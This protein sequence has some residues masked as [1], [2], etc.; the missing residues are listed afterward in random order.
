[1][2]HIRIAGSSLSLGVASLLL[3]GATMAF[4]TDQ[5]NSVGNVFSA[6]TI[7]SK[8]SDTDETDQ[9]TI[10][11]SF[12]FSNGSPGKVFEETLG[13]KN[14]GTARAKSIKFDFQNTVVEGPPPGNVATV[15][16]PRV[17]E[18]N[19]MTFNGINFF[20]V[21]NV[22]DLNGNGYK[23]LEDIANTDIPFITYS[24]PQSSSHTFYIR[25]LL[26]PDFTV[27]QHQGDAVTVNLSI[28][29]S[30]ADPP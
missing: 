19:S 13:V 4:F 7:I 24:D 17:L 25:G 6:G 10:N 22:A 14:L 15:P 12:G 20:T 30:E 16:I 29:L 28:T 23:D 3:T 5:G 2:D 27:N 1:M 9:D 8:L 21:G 11:G 26:R 18:V